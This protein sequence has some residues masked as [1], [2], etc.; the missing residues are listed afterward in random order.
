MARLSDRSLS[1]L[2][3]IIYLSGT[4]KRVSHAIGLLQSA[5]MAGQPVKGL[6]SSPVASKLA[7]FIGLKDKL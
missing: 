5:T 2:A 3:S 4:R 6:S 7:G 1:L